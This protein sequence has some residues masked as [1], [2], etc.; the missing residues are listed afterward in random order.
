MLDEFVNM[1]GDADYKHEGDILYMQMQ[2]KKVSI[3]SKERDITVTVDGEPI[4][5]LPGTFQVYQ[6]ALTLKI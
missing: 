4:G 2:A 3:K 1:K 6:S 5:V